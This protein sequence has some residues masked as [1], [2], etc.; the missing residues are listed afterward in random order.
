MDVIGEV[1]CANGE[2]GITGEADVEDF[3]GSAVHRAGGLE[4]V[5]GGIAENILHILTNPSFSG[6]GRL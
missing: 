3:R 6:P 1:H 4:P 2:D 5:A